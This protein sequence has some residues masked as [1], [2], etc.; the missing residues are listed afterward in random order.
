MEEITKGLSCR[1]AKSIKQDQNIHQLTNM[2]WG[3]LE[4]I[5]FTKFKK[6]HSLVRTPEEFKNSEVEN[7]HFLLGYIVSQKKYCSILTMIDLRP[8]SR[9]RCISE[10]MFLVKKKISIKVRALV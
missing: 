10:R 2:P 9:Q 1:H 8:K 7:F 6:I 3:G 4:D 5:P